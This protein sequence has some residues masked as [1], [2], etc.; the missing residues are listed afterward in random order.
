MNFNQTAILIPRDTTTNYI[1]TIFGKDDSAEKEVI[2]NLFTMVLTNPRMLA[3]LT[4]NS[5]SREQ[6]QQAFLAELLKKPDEAKQLVQELI[7]AG[8]IEM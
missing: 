7:K 3:A 4:D 1:P 5:L 8:V 6:Q 2:A